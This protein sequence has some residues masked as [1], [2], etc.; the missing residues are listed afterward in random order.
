MVRILVKPHKIKDKRTGKVRTVP[1]EYDVDWRPIGVGPSGKAREVLEA[2]DK[3]A[4][5]RFVD[6]YVHDVRRV[7]AGLKPLNPN[8]KGLTLA[9]LV[10][11]GLNRM[12]P[13]GREG[14]RSFLRPHVLNAP[15][16]KVRA[17]LVTSAMLEEVAVG[18][19]A[20]GR[21]PVTVDKLRSY[22]SFIYRQADRLGEVRCGDPT[23]DM[24]NR[25][26]KRNRGKGVGMRRASTGILFYEESVRV[27]H[28]WAVRPGKHR[29]V[30]ALACS[31]ACFS[32][33]RK[34]ETRRLLIENIH[35]EAA[36]PFAQ[37]VDT[38]G[39]KDRVVPLFP[40]QMELLDKV[41]GKRTAGPLLLSRYGKPF[42]KDAPMAS[43][44]KTACEGLGIPKPVTY[45]G[46]RRSACTWWAMEGVDVRTA[47]HWM[48]HTDIRLT[49]DIYEQVPQMRHMAEAQKLRVSRDAGADRDLAAVAAMAGGGHG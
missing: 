1:G 21:S 36:Q 12:P 28:W 14:A 27:V 35:R 46:L 34:G 10:E 23:T 25:K 37:L 40:E 29:D 13:E 49:V 33:L 3:V 48:G 42:A 4:A 15:L 6:E 38:K 7:G 19:E 32:A 31:L 22:L 26:S 2:V 45:Q 39:G 24:V 17:E 47:Q 5:Q 43:W 16:G 18:L 41:I 11:W 20:A 44:V 8:P 9:G 30:K